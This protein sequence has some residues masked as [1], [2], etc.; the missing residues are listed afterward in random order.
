VV[1]ERV[2]LP[3]PDELRELRRT[4]RPLC[5]L[6]TQIPLSEFDVIG[7]SLTY[8]LD[9]P[10]VLTMLSLGG[11][12]LSA[13]E[14]KESDPL[15]I[16]GGPGPT[17]NPEP[18][19]DFV[20]LFV[21][22][23]SEQLIIPFGMCLYTCVSAP[24]R[25]A[26]LMLGEMPGIYAPALYEPRYQDDGTL[27]ELVS[28]AGAPPR[29]TRQVTRRLDEW[30]TCSR[31]LTRDTT[32][33]EMFLIEIS[34]G[35]GRGC[36]FCVADYAYRP[37]RRRSVE[38]IL[39]TAR[40][41]LQHRET[42]GLI[43]A[44]VSDYPEMDRLCAELMAAGAKIAVASLRADSVTP[45]LLETLARS[46]SNS[47]TLAPEAGTERL[48][49]QIHKTISDEQFVA[50]ARAASRLG[51]KQMKLYFMIGLPGETD[52]DIAAI[53]ELV[54]QVKREA[55]LRQV[56]VAVSA[57]VPKPSTPLER[58]VMAKPADVKRKLAAIQSELAGEAGIELG[59]ETEW[60]SF[61][62]GVL[63]RGDRRVGKLMLE[64]WQAGGSRSA[65]RRALGTA[66]EWYACRD[67]GADELLPWAHIG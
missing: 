1:C 34:R 31:V 7:F 39:E 5:S 29:I 11:V 13:S 58:V 40:R 2:F 6:E 30:E 42:I 41:G 67:R 45:G 48:R 60:P 22:G 54:R 25:E 19:S 55:R 32:F 66:G 3:D 20:D 26:L 10:N 63:A 65:W 17:F 33:G 64:A 27:S 24:R 46:G 14:R 8:E 12:P 61:L 51:I 21:I 35:C 38:H 23:D 18:M 43:G 50:A 52:A 49:S 37:L 53:P 36:R 57:F 4:R 47:I 16:A 62:Q 59:G 56:S 9:Y 28:G 15:V 44:A